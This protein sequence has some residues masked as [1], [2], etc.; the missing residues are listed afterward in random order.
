MKK[1]KRLGLLLFT[2]LA[3]AAFIPSVASAE[4]FEG[5]I[6]LDDGSGDPG[7]PCAILFDYN[8][9]FPGSGPLSNVETDGCL[10]EGM[11]INVTGSSLSASFSGTG[12][13][14]INGSVTVALLGGL[15]SCT[16][17]IDPPGLVGTY[18]YPPLVGTWTGTATKTGGSSLCPPSVSIT[19]TVP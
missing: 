16:Y 14:A 4:S 11:P 15:I 7:E 1:L 19:I 13:S 12:S 6:A 3:F 2:V 9:G 5:T 8:G 10:Y 17:T 18:T